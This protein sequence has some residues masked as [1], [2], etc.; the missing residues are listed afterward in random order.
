M[1]CTEYMIFKE[2][3][4]QLQEKYEDEKKYY[5]AAGE[6]IK[7]ASQKYDNLVSTKERVLYCLF[8]LLLCRRISLMVVI[9]MKIF[10]LIIFYQNN[11]TLNIQG[12]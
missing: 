1:E 11:H 5:K 4:R 9:M 8:R 3:N 7:K 12:P 6:F 10:K 2:T